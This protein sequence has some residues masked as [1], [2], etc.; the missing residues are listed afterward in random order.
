[1]EMRFFWI[2]DKV[3]QSKYDLSWHPDQENLTD[4]QSKHHNRAHH[5]AVCPWY[6]HQS[7]SPLYLPWAV[8]PSALKGCAG[9]LKDG[10]L[11][12]VPL[13]RVP[14]IQ[15]MSEHVVSTAA[16]MSDSH[17]TCYLQVPRVPTW[18]DLTRSLA[19]FGGRALLHVA[20]N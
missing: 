11:R 6:L 10:H 13:P 8:R 12:K 2:G 16:V 3:A 17:D 15:S 14:R 19:G 1:M 20:I 4:Y 18:S 5:K 9:T 7:N